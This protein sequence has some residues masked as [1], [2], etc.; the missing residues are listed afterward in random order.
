MRRRR[1]GDDA[2]AANARAAAVRSIEEFGGRLT[3][4]HRASLMKRPDVI[5][6]MS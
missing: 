6:L 2:A 3:D 1:L 4:A 5:E